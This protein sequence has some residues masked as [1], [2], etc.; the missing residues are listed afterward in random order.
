MRVHEFL[1]EI[2]LVL[3]FHF[4]MTNCTKWMIITA[5]IKFFKSRNQSFTLG[6]NEIATVCTE[7]Y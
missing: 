1:L 7:R 5:G 2:D 3:F 4:V 6:V